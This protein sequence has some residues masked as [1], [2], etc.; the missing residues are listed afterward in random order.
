MV[1]LGLFLKHGQRQEEVCEPDFYYLPPPQ[2][3]RLYDI[4]HTIQLLNK[5]VGHEQ[6]GKVLVG[7]QPPDDSADFSFHIKLNSTIPQE[8]P[9]GFGP[10]ET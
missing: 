7:T 8:Q 2:C 9:R 5:I 10:I 6:A 1:M 3:S 4:Q